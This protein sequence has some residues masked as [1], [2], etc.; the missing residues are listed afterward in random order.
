MS[1]HDALPPTRLAGL[2][3]DPVEVRKTVL[4]I[5]YSGRGSH[6]GSAMSAVEMLLAIY[7][8]VDL[9]RIRQQAPDRDRVIVSKGHCAAA[10]YSVMA[11]AGLL[12]FEDLAGYRLDDSLLAGCVSHA[13]SFVEHST[14]A[15][16]HGLPV[17]AGCAVGLRA[18]GFDS[19]W[20]FALV[21]DG[22]IQEGSV[23]EALMFARHH[24]LWNLI[25]L[26]DDNRIGNI[27]RTAAVIDMNPLSDRFAGFGFQAFV[28]DGHDP[29]A[30]LATIGKIKEARVP[31]V[32]ICRT[33]KGRDVP[34]AENQPIWHYRTLSQPDFEAAIAH[35]EELRGGPS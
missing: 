25:T 21:G 11:H 19:S 27:T 13:V 15:L 29:S 30:L 12:P 7:S 34:F 26:V 2:V 32:I 6:L 22:E 3:A 20:V 10:V 4:E 5:L 28:V 31:S 17:A 18:R 35:L 8:A 1:A 23:W 9:N 33:V 16:G 14:G 24:R